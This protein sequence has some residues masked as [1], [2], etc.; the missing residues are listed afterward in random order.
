[1]ATIL[2]EFSRKS[3]AKTLAL[4][5]AD[6]E[7]QSRL[8]ALG[9][10]VI[11]F[12]EDRAQ[13][14]DRL[15]DKLI[16]LED[17]RAAATDADG[18]TALPD[19]SPPAAA[20]DADEKENE[21]F[22]TEGAAALA[23]ARR[24][25]ARYSVPRARRRL[26][27][28]RRESKIPLKSH[29]ALRNEVRGKLR[30][31]ELFGSQIS[32]DRPISVTRFA[33]DGQTV[34]TGNWGGSV[35]LLDVPSMKVVKTWKGHADRVGGVGWHP[36]ATLEGSGDG[37]GRVDLVTGGGEGDVKLWSLD[38]DD[39]LAVMKGH[40]GRVCRTEFHPSGRYV[41]SASYD[42][43]WRLWDV[44]TQQEL[45]LQ[46]GHAKEVYCLAYNVDGSLLVSGGLDGFGRV[47]D[48]R[49]GRTIW[50]LSG[51]LKEI[52][53]VDWSAEG[54]RILTGAGDGLSICWDVRMVREIAKIPT[55][56]KGVTDLRWY[57]GF[58]HPLM[59]ADANGGGDGRGERPRK[60]G[61]FTVSCG[62]DKN[63]QLYSTGDWSPARM[64]TGHT[65]N[66]LS[67]DVSNDGKWIVS[68]SYDRTVKLW[69]RDDL[70]PV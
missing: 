38:S 55:H 70:S 11:V 2:D 32:G 58:D 13:R 15:R 28:L 33:P 40:S 22:Y 57:K 21:D 42:T 16:A 44:A 35:R 46:E 52:Y 54:H 56:A 48:L 39:P 49:S 41:A 6:P 37:A 4:P 20:A 26:D 50:L 43:T 51:H 68:G 27:V 23:A 9:E 3:R 66:V 10:P 45:L 30:S 53:G 63:V 61:T 69:A 60:S 18:D 29:V 12:A 8:R 31:V 67:C 65:G 7:I 47:W 34:A 17:A 19:A 59:H 14:R 62:F 36:G 5:T 25:I 24:Q 64:L 1:M